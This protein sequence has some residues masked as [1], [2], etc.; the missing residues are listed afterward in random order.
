[1]G[2]NANIRCMSIRCKGRHGHLCHCGEPTPE[3]IA[4]CECWPVKLRLKANSDESQQNL[5]LVR[6]FCIKRVSDDTAR[7]GI[8]SFKGAA[9]GDH[10]NLWEAV[11][12]H[13]QEL[14]S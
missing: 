11:A 14:E 8:S 4:W 13:R 9:H 2:M 6:A 10:Q 3:R 1:M 7:H 12:D 5:W